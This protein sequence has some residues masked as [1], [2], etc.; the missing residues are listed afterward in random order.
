MFDRPGITAETGRRPVRAGAQWHHCQN[1]SSIRAEAL[2]P[3]GP[4]ERGKGRKTR[5][6][7][8]ALAHAEAPPWPP[9]TPHPLW[10]DMQGWETVA[11]LWFLPL[12]KNPN[13]T[14]KKKK[15]KVPVRG[16]QVQACVR[17]EIVWT[18]LSPHAVQGGQ[19][20]HCSAHMCV[21]STS[22]TNIIRAQPNNTGLNL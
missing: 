19:A 14:K 8:R 3:G 12:I 20:G 21:R 4:G 13:L 5:A 15:K 6:L 16:R 22:V 18:D 7:F 11:L 2:Q 9:P 1:T 10:P 17:A